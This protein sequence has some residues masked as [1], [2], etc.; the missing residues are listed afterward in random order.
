MD[1]NL[2]SLLQKATSSLAV[3]LEKVLPSLVND[4]WKEAVVNILSFQQQ[5]RVKERR[6]ISLISLDLAA[7]LRV[8]DKNWYQIST[9]LNL[10]AGARHLKQ[11]WGDTNLFSTKQVVAT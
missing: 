10:E 2:N 9:K 5:R 3:Y 4:W 8:L 1:N 6:I 7:L 11:N